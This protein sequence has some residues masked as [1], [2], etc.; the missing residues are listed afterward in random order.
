MDVIPSHFPSRRLFELDWGS[1]SDLE[2]VALLIGPGTTERRALSDAQRLFDA[3]GSFRQ[4]RELGYEGIRGV[5]LNRKKALSLLAAL[6]LSRRVQKIPLFPGQ[7]F[8][9]V[10]SSDSRYLTDEPSHYVR[11]AKPL[12]KTP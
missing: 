4:L 6:Q 7:S 2:L 5:G 3:A 11:T 1:L 8:R 12:S 10:E 9:S